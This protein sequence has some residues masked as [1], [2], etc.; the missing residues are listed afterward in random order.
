MGSRFADRR[1]IRREAPLQHAQEGDAARGIQPAV[2]AHDFAG[3]G[4]ARGLAPAGQQGRRQLLQRLL[5]HGIVQGGADGARHQS[6]PLV[7]QGLQEVI[8]ELRLADDALGHDAD[9]G[10][11]ILHSQSTILYTRMRRMH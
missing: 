8:Q 2:A 11:S 3:D 4:D 6:A 7:R 10:Y 5:A 9:S 1:R